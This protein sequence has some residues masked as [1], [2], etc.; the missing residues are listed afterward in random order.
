MNNSKHERFLKITSAREKKISEMIR[1]MGNCSNKNNYAYTQAEAEEIFDKIEANI[2]EARLKFGLPAN[3]REE[4]KAEFEENYTWAEGFMRSVN[5]YENKIAVIY[6][7]KNIKISYGELNR[8]SD[9]YADFI[10]GKT[11]R[12]MY[13]MRNIPEFIFIYIACHKTGVTGCPVDIRLAP[14]E[15][16]M[17]IDDV[18]PDI[19]IYEYRGDTELAL[20]M[21]KH[22]P[23]QLL[24]VGYPKDKKLLPGHIRFEEIAQMPEC[25]KQEISCSIYDETTYF[26]TSGTTGRQKCSPVTCINEVMSAQSIM[27]YMSLGHNDITLNITPWHHRG[28]LHCM[29]PGSVLFAGGTVIAMPDFNG[30]KCLDIIEKYRV[31]VLSGMPPRF[32]VLSIAQKKHCRNLASLKYM[33]TMGGMLTASE[34]AEYYR[35]ITKNIYN[36]YGTTE[37]F[38]NTVLTPDD[39]PFM[40]G[41]S[42]IPCSEDDVR[43]VRLYDRKKAQPDDIIEKGSKELGEIIIKSVSKCAGTYRGESVSANKAYYKG[44]LYTGDIGTWDSDGCITVKGRRDDM[45]I[46]EGEKIYPAAVE[47]VLG[48]HPKVRDCV[49]TS[50]SDEL[51]G[52]SITAYVVK[53]ENE[54]LTIKE[55]D[56]FCKDSLL[57]ANHHRPQ[58]YRFKKVIP[59][60]AS[61]K[62]LRYK[63]KKMA[64]SDLKKGMLHKVY[65]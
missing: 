44:F 4:F 27:M 40:S 46:C 55:L 9:I 24:V 8:I 38:F 29:G 63:I 22:K 12:V 30:E 65:D 62:K 47:E 43:I 59:K 39:I 13:S 48:S 28:G 36:I 57:I 37:T 53:E 42:G 3:K 58:Y 23:K 35:T 51:R 25:P 32:R 17:I 11:Q 14:G 21:A 64:A 56:E 18:K 16:A 10:K 34:C 33:V 31:T 60:G 50:V 61:G 52:E 19:F 49:V 5:K 6:P 45:I 54:S 26:Y 2:R 7:D 41:A 20:K 1:L 15:T